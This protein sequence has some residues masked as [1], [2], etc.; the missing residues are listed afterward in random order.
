[1]TRVGENISAV[2]FPVIFYVG[3]RSFLSLNIGISTLF[4]LYTQV[5]AGMFLAIAEPLSFSY[6]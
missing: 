5:Q 4:A 1:M 6:K 2:L 3:F